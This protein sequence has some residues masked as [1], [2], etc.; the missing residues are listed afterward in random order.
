MP[1]LLGSSA[2]RIRLMAAA[3]TR[4][5]LTTSPEQAAER[6]QSEEEAK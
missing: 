4:A 2:P 1:P 5:P 3:T 6:A